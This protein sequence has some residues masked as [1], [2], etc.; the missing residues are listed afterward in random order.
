VNDSGVVNASRGI[1][2]RCHLVRHHPAPISNI[3]SRSV[4]A[5]RTQQFPRRERLARHWRRG[6]VEG[7]LRSATPGAEN[8]S[9]RGPPQRSSKPV[10]LSLA[11][12][13]GLG[14]ALGARAGHSGR[15]RVCVYCP[16]PHILPRP[17]AVLVTSLARALINVGT[18]AITFRRQ[19]QQGSVDGILGGHYGAAGRR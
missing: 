11:L 13:A 5:L 3:V 4:F 6:V 19:M 10:R 1:R 9:R 7:P 16:C 18:H 14:I 12:G 8:R 15:M 17:F 2:V